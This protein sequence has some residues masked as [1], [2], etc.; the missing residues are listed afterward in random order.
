MASAGIMYQK[1]RI[2]GTIPSA[3]IIAT[4]FHGMMVIYLQKYVTLLIATLATLYVM[5]KT[6]K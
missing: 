4:E 2:F 1:K 5:K 3:N 6:V